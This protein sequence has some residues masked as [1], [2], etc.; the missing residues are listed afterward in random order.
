MRILSVTQLKP[1]KVYGSDFSFPVSCQT[2]LVLDKKNPANKKEHQFIYQQGSQYGT[3]G[4]CCVYLSNDDLF[5]LEEKG[6][7]S[8]KKTK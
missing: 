6:L 3:V 7:I 2:R 5:L 4:D 8:I 1:L